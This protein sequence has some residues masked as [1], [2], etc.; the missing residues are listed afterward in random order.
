MSVHLIVGPPYNRKETTSKLYHNS[1][2]SSLLLSPLLSVSFSLESSSYSHSN[3]R[4]ISNLLSNL[5]HLCTSSIMSHIPL[6][7]IF[8]SSKF[9]TCFLLHV[10]GSEFVSL[11]LFISKPV[12]NTYIITTPPFFIIGV[13]QS[14]VFG[15]EFQNTA[16]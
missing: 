10:L 8:I 2:P 5:S 12:V 13:Y 4:P 6:S 15:T 3:I 11:I 14:I 7:S 16:P 1:W 9:I